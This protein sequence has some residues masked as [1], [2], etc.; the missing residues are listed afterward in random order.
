[1]ALTKVTNAMQNSASASVLDYGATG[2]G[3]TDDSAAVQ[4]AL[5][6]NSS[7]YFPPGEYQIKDIAIDGS[8]KEIIAPMGAWLRHSF[9]DSGA[10][11]MF[12]IAE[13]SNVDFLNIVID[14]ITMGANGGHIFRC[15]GSMNH[16]RIN[17][18][19]VDHNTLDKSIIF[20]DDT[21]FYFN[22]ITGLFWR[23]S[24]AHTQ[25][26]IRLWSTSNKISANE[27]DILRPDRSGSRHFMELLST[28]TTDYNY[29]NM[30]KLSNPEVCSGGVLKLQ[31]AMNTVVERMHCFDTGITRDTVNH[32]VEIGVPG[33][34][35]QNTKINDYQRNSGTLGAG[36]VDI[37]LGDASTTFISNPS[38]VSSGTEIEIDINGEPN[39]L[40]LGGSFYNVSNATTSNT[41]ILS[42][43]E[44]LST[45]KLL[46]TP[47]AGQLTIESGVIEVTDSVHRVDTEAFAAS[48][49]LDTINGGSDGYVLILKTFVN[50]RDVTLK[51]GTGNL[52]LAGDFVLSDTKDT[53][54][55]RYDAL[56]TGWVE[57]SRSDNAA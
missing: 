38:G 27:F 26:A 10:T 48:D 28:S 29:S 33:F 19:N 24:E 13:T 11:N 49:D 21:G 55:L 31:R 40:I 37:F 47:Q 51:D 36:L 12:R 3:V 15:Y 7:I 6:A 14:K 43:L 50:A 54:M 32:M 22:K 34:L 53:I 57:I 18:N 16:S 1:M 30:I 2:D 39:T 25:P 52:L 8:D 44:G 41:V 17:V 5:N 56:A 42:A 23:S 35:C 46:V 4:A 9:A 20:V 45:P